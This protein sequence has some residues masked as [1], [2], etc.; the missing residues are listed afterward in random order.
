MFSVLRVI[1][2][3]HGDSRVCSAIAVWQVCMYGIHVYAPLRGGPYPLLLTFAYCPPRPDPG[4]TCLA[5]E[6]GLPPDTV[7][8][9]GAG[10]PEPAARVSGPRQPAKGAWAAYL[11]LEWDP[12]LSMVDPYRAYRLSKRLSTWQPQPPRAVHAPLPPSERSLLPPLSAPLL[13]MRPL[14]PLAQPPPLSGPVY[15]SGRCEIMGAMHPEAKGGR[16]TSSAPVQWGLDRSF[17]VCS[18]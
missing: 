9:G 14:S 17:C 18:A 6:G 1:G 5:E 8:V 10:I 2:N 13:A 3:R 7:R 16:L 12:L 4:G 15:L 11:C